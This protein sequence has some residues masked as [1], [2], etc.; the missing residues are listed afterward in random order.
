MNEASESFL[1]GAGQRLRNVSQLWSVYTLT[2]LLAYGFAMYNLLLAGDDWDVLVGSFSPVQPLSIG[3]WTQTVIW[4]LVGYQIFSPPFTIAATCAAYLIFGCACCLCLGLTRRESWLIFVC[5]L[6]S[7]PFNAEPLV[8][9]M[10]HLDLAFGIVMATVS[11]LLTVRSYELFEGRRK[12]TAMVQ[13]TAAV[14]AFVLSAAAYQTLALFAP[15]LVLVRLVGM[16]RQRRESVRLL[17]SMARL[18]GCSAVIVSIGLL[19]YMESMRVASWLTDT[20]LISTGGYAVVDSFVTSWSELFR[21]VS[22]GLDLWRDVL[23]HSQ[24][25]FPIFPK[26]L[27]LVMAAALIVAMASGGTEP[28]YAGPHRPITV[29]DSTVRIAVLCGAIIMLFLAP[30]ALGMVRKFSSYRYDNMVGMAV[31]WSVV[32]ALLFDMTNNRRRRWGIGLLAFSVIAIF[33]FEQGHSSV[34]S[35]LL[36]RHDLAIANRMLERITQNQAFAPYAKKGQA[37]I[38]FYDAGQR[39]VL[40]RPLSADQ[41]VIG[42]ID[43]CGIFNCQLRRVSSAFRQLSEADMAYQVSFWPDIPV[44][45]SAEDRRQLEQRI[46]NASSWPA[47][48]AVIFGPGFIVVV[49]RKGP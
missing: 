14:I 9:D 12:C 19:F 7:F 35:F 29:L 25:L 26:V 6:V 15:A 42:A 17:G 4:R 38:L 27:F 34:T 33:V 43:G 41:F 37:D 23:F 1:S 32:F 11:G 2:V 18:L 24:H 30:L 22:A 46:Q 47:P 44:T 10:A 20:P 3:R 21:Q 8:F 28:D 5:M 48:D 49:L 16:L 40:P 36:N 45:T 39:D 31:P 13:A